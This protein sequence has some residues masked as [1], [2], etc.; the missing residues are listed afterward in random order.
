MQR[1]ALDHRGFTF[2]SLS[3][4]GQLDMAPPA[5]EQVSVLSA[6]YRTL[7]SGAR[8]RISAAHVADA[9]ATA[10]RSAAAPADAGYGAATAAGS[11]T[12]GGATRDAAA[13]TARSATTGTWCCGWPGGH[14]GRRSGRRCCAT[15]WP[16]IA[17]ATCNREDEH[18]CTAESATAALASD[19]IRFPTL[20]SRHVYPVHLSVPSRASVK[21]D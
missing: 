1:S 21:Q 8:S 11:A 17:A 3:R 2:G 9:T 4:W 5:W 15:A 16:S 13:T 18:G 14:A 6:H 19:L 10:A 20:H 7:K 12:T